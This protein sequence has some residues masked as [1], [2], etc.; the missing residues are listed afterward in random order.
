VARALIDAVQELLDATVYLRQ[1]VAETDKAGGGDEAAWSYRPLYQ[2]T[3]GSLFA[4]VRVLMARDAAAVRTRCAACARADSDDAL[5]RYHGRDGGR[6]HSRRETVVDITPERL[7]RLEAIERAAI[8]W[9]AA[10]GYG[11]V[12]D[13]L[14]RLAAELAAASPVAAAPQPWTPTPEDIDRAA[15]AGLAAVLQLQG[16]M[17][18]FGAVW[19]EQGEDVTADAERIAE[20]K[21]IHGW[22]TVED[23]KCFEAAVRASLAASE[24]AWRAAGGASLMGGGQSKAGV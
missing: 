17:T 21:R 2:A 19:A 4:A 24:A 18:S 12:D 20:G 6:Q 7:A 3:L 14:M 8:Q 22:P 10:R 23:R 13:A 15:R 1:L 5:E 11:D 9:G 16:G